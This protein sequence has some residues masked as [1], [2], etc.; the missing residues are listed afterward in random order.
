MPI[1]AKKA[2]SACVM[3]LFAF[4]LVLEPLARTALAIPDNIRKDPAK[5]HNYLEKVEAEGDFFDY[6]DEVNELT[7]KE[8]R[9]LE[10]YEDDMREREERIQR[11]RE[12]RIA[13]KSALD[14]RVLRDLRLNPGSET[15]AH[16]AAFFVETLF[17]E[18][19][20]VSGQEIQD[21][22][23]ALLDM[24]KDPELI[25]AQQAQVLRTY[26][27]TLANLTAQ[28]ME[29]ERKAAIKLATDRAKIYRE[30]YDFKR[31]AQAD[32]VWTPKEEEEY[33][34]L[35]DKWSELWQPTAEEQQAMAEFD[36]LRQETF[37]EIR[38]LTKHLGTLD[39]NQIAEQKAD[40]KWWIELQEIEDVPWLGD[41]HFTF[42]GEM[43][44][45]MV[46]DYFNQAEDFIYYWNIMIATQLYLQKTNLTDDQRK[47]AEGI[48][49][50]AEWARFHADFNMKRD[51]DVILYGTAADLVIFAAGGPA[52]AVAA[53]IGRGTSRVFTALWTRLFG[54]A[55]KETA[56][57]GAKAGGKGAVGIGGA[58]SKELVEE[59][60]Q[61]GRKLGLNEKELADIA[62]GALKE[63]DPR[64]AGKWAWLLQGANQGMILQL[65]NFNKMVE[66]ALEM[67]VRKEIIDDIIARAPKEAAE[68]FMKSV[69]NK[70][71]LAM[72]QATDGRIVLPLFSEATQQAGK[73]VVRTVDSEFDLA[74][75]KLKE[76][77]GD[78]VMSWLTPKPVGM[79][80]RGLLQLYKTFKETGKLPAN[81]T[82]EQLNILRQVQKMY[83]EGDR[84]IY[85]FEWL[86]GNEGLI[87]AGDDAF[88]KAAD[89][90]LGSSSQ[91]AREV[92]SGANPNPHSAAGNMAEFR[93]ATTMKS[94]TP[95]EIA[96]MEQASTMNVPPPGSMTTPPTPKGTTP[97]PG[98][99]GDSTVPP[100][101]CST[102]G[103]KPP[104]SSF[105]LFPDGKRP[106]MFHFRPPSGTH[107]EHKDDRPKP[108]YTI[109]IGDKE[110]QCGYATVTPRRLP[111]VVQ[112]VE[113]D[114]TRVKLLPNDQYFNSTGSF[115]KKLPDQWGIKRI[116]FDDTKD[117]AWHAMKR[118]AKPVIVAVIDT[119]LDWRHPDID[120]KK[121]WYNPNEIPGNH[122][123]DDK[124]GYIDDMIGWNFIT[125]S[126]IPW[127]R[128]GHGTFVTGL[129]AA[130]TANLWGMAGINPEA[131][132]MVL[133]A[134]DDSGSTLASRVTEA[135][136]YAADN[137]ARVINL[138]LGGRKLTHAE[139]LAVD[140]A[141]TKGAV[142]VAAVGNEGKD[143]ADFA[144]ANLNHVIG[145]AA[146][147][148]ND[149]RAP[150]SNWGPAVDIAAPGVDMLSLRAQNSDLAFNVVKKYTWGDNVVGY[151]YYRATGTSFAAPL[152]SATASLILANNPRLTNTQVERMLLQSA[153]D[154]ETPGV[155]QYSGYGL[156]DARAAMKADPEFF[157]DAAI[158]GVQVT[159]K[160][161]RQALAVLGTANADRFGNA[162]VE[163]GQGKDPKSWKTV[164]KKVKKPVQGGELG[165]FPTAELAGSQ[166]WTLRLVV[167]HKNGTEREARFLLSLN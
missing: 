14:N 149:A 81:L 35:N 3:L 167:E 153:R 162:R 45:H 72:I 101:S 130:K 117:S 123:D 5:L 82:A 24:P 68:E 146:T 50:L 46:D 119:G 77:F 85:I 98:H 11:E 91:A 132:I 41:V 163:M 106:F 6:M 137:G 94:L 23:K 34:K 27:E 66:Q 12:D 156:L 36:D 125:H 18:D 128:D 42:T 1:P 104:S 135:I 122:I 112:L 113:D 141:H 56:E 79:D 93:N 57:A 144:P 58:F 88:M 164:V 44:E 155:D 74:V 148:E 8:R 32:G 67:G 78:N 90:A 76:I 160:G 2:F 107:A 140:Y 129:I 17:S 103:A 52:E 48:Y 133:K 154:I 31:E 15:E 59:A 21:T 99:L 138:S 25:A 4:S 116:G 102:K 75:A 97:S 13:R 165:D 39:L 83:K 89:D 51:M 145:V 86:A 110:I 147:D 95:E 84:T 131:R 151:K 80:A 7:A 19:P 55:A 134:L 33:D 115:K 161:K 22:T 28:A 126:N 20:S 26:E 120:S 63:V 139:K 64:T 127:D 105:D 71:A 96:R 70:L 100:P 47:I 152:V 43:A 69:R 143:T 124:N 9:K 166:Q 62:E 60:V 136:V 159:G 111:K 87:K 65:K 108:Y 61:Q 158:S 142:V 121:L 40:A 92:P 49:K 118:G 30:L 114:P 150:F 29:S 38:D 157:V 109:T 10:K 37:Q 73:G 53:W 16:V 54:C